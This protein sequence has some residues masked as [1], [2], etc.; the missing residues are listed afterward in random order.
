MSVEPAAYD[1][2]NPDRLNRER[3]QALQVVAETFARRVSAVL[4]TSLRTIV[5]SQVVALRQPTYAEYLEGMARPSVLSAL[6]L[7]GIPGGG[8]LQLAHVDVMAFLDRLLGGAGTG[9]QPERPLTEI[10][11]GLASAFIAQVAGELSFAFG[12]IGELHVRQTALETS[13]RFHQVARST[14]TVVVVDLVAQVDDRAVP[15]SLCLTLGPLSPVLASIERTV[16]DEEGERVAHARQVVRRR[17]EQV[18]IDVRVA[19]QDVSLTSREV[20]AL[21]VGDVVPLRH[22]TSEPLVVTAG[23]VRV[24]HATPGSHGRQLAAQIVP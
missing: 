11:T 7:G 13:V 16:D 5:T 10:E 2:R 18:E 12:A 23:G 14:D 17:I 21:A 19:F 22:R 1:F 24:A 15:F 9:E 3:E 8:H 4:S 20:F 6:A